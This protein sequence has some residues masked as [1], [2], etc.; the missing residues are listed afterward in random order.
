MDRSKNQPKR[1]I[2]K[3]KGHAPPGDFIAL[4]SKPRSGSDPL[5]ERHGPVPSQKK[6]LPSTSGGLE[7]K[8]EA[9][10][11]PLGASLV[12]KPKLLGTSQVFTPL[13]RP[14]DP[15]RRASPAPQQ[16]QQY[17]EIAVDFEPAELI[18]SIYGAED[19]GDDD[20]LEGL[21]CGAVRYLRANRAKP[22]TTMYLSL[23][24]LA[25]TK[26]ALFDSDIIIEAMCS[27]LKRDVAINFKSKGNALV[28]VLTCNILMVAFQDEE[29]WPDQF[30]KVYLE[31]SLGERVW[32]DREDCKGFVENI[33][34]AFNTKMPPKSSLVGDLPKAMEVASAS[35]GH[36]TSDD[37]RSQDGAE[38]MM[39]QG[40]SISDELNVPVFPRYTYQQT[41]IE[42]FVIDT[43]K[44]QLTRRQGIDTASRNLLKLIAATCGYPEIRSLAVQRLEMWLQN[45][46]LTRPAQDLL[47][48]ICLNCNQHSQVDVDIMAALI[49]IR[50]KTKPL[51]NQYMAS[52]RELLSQ[53]SDNTRTLLTHIVY[54]ELSTARNPNNMSLIAVILQHSPESSAR[55][56]AEIFQDFLCNKDDYLRALRALLREIVRSVK[57]DM[58][59]SA[60]A[61][62]LMQERIEA[63]LTDLD[64]AV[65]DRVLLSS[66]DL[67]TLTGLMSVT[68][69][70]REAVNSFDRGDFKDIEVLKTFQNQMAVIQRDSVWWLHTFVPKVFELKPNDYAHCL[71]KLLFLEKA[72]HYYNKD[73]WPPE[74]DRT[75][76]LRIASE[77]PVH[78]DTLMRLLIIGLSRELPISNVDAIELADRLIKR[79]AALQDEGFPVLQ[80]ERLELIDALLNLSTYHHPENITLPKGYQPPMLAITNLYWK[81]WNM[82][83]ILAAF[84]PVSFGYAAWET[85]PTLK[86]MMEMVMTNNYK[87][88]PPTTATDENLIEEITNREKQIQQTEKQ[89]I[90]EFEGHLAAASRPVVTITESNSLLIT[91]LMKMEPNGPARRPPT[92]VLDQL[93]TVNKSL[94]IGHMLC[95]SR[96]P[97]FLMDVIQ[98]QGTSSSMPWL[99]ELVESSDGS[100][101]V[102]PVQ[103]LCEFL[104][105]ESPDL[106]SAQEEDDESNAQKYK[107]KQ[108]VKKQEQLLSRLQKLLYD[109]DANY[110]T[111]VEVIDYF[112]KRLGNQQSSSRA[113]AVKGLSMVLSRSHLDSGEGMVCDNVGLMIPTHQ[114]LLTQLPVIPHFDMVRSKVCNALRQACQMETDVSAVSAYIVFLSEHGSS[115]QLHEVADIALDL[116]QL[117]VERSSVM[118]QVMPQDD[119]QNSPRADLV[120]ASLINFFIKYLRWAKEPEK[121]AYSWSDSQ[122][123][124]LLKWTTGE[125]A[126]L[127]ILVVHA[128]IILLTY[129]SPK[130]TSEFQELS[131]NWFPPDGPSPAAYLV[132]TSE[133]ALLLPDWLKLRMIRSKVQTLVDAALVDLEPAQLLLFV[134]SFGI[135][136]ESMKKLLQCLDKAVTTDMY[137]LEQHI[138]DK[139]YMAQLV[140]VQHL[141]GAKGGDNFYKMLTDGEE[142]PKTDDTRGRSPEPRK[143]KSPISLMYTQDDWSNKYRR[144]GHI[145]A[146]LK[147]MFQD[148]SLSTTDRE[149]MYKSLQKA[150]MKNTKLSVAAIECLEQIFSSRDADNFIKAMFRFSD[151]SCPLLRILLAKQRKSTGRVDTIMAWILDRATDSKSPLT[152]LAKQHFTTGKPSKALKTIPGKLMNGDQLNQ[153]KFIAAVDNMDI[154]CHSKLEELVNLSMKEGLRKDV[155]KAQLCST[156]LVDKDRGRKM[157]ASAAGLFIDWL[158]LLDPEIIEACPS[159]VQTLVFAKQETKDAK[160][161]TSH[162]PYL[163]A[164]LTHQSSWSS[165]HS[166]VRSLLK[167]DADKG[168][169]ESSAV[170]DFL[171]ACIHIPKIWQGRERS[172]PKHHKLEDVFNLTTDQLCCIVDHVITEAWEMSDG[173]CSESALECLEWRVQLLEKCC[174]NYRSRIVTVIQHICNQVKKQSPKSSLCQHLVLEVYFHYP[175][176]YHWVSDLNFILKDIQTAQDCGASKLDGISHRLLTSLS[177]AKHGSR[178]ENRM[179]D[180]NI[181]CRKMATEHPILLLR[182]LPMM[183]ALLKGRTHFTIGEFRHKNH[184]ILFT[185]VLGILELLMPQVFQKEYTSLG[186]IIEAYFAAIGNYG[187]QNPLLMPLINKFI[188][189]IHQF[190]AHDPVRA[191]KILHNHVELLNALTNLLPDFSIL[192]S[193]LAGLS[194]PRQE[195]E[196][197]ENPLEAGPVLLPTR[198]S[199]PWTMAELN[200]FLVKIGKDR[201]E[202]DITE[203]LEDLDNTAKR[204]VEILEH[205][206]GDLKR[207]IYHNNERIRNIAFMLVMRHVRSNPSSCG[208]FVP[209]YIKCLESE[210]HEVI[211]SALR[212]L[213]EFSLLGQEHASTILQKAFSAG[214][215]S[216]I[217]MGS[218]ITDAIQLLNMETM[219]Q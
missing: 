208:Q 155:R 77:V 214:I 157:S 32:V 144:P 118:A 178:S 166:C 187:F 112:L 131:D 73:N 31:D 1:P 89:E 205:F 101:D 198:S 206:L 174:C 87:F 161:Q 57:Y 149:Q 44:D 156:F 76:L 42:T 98:R 27:L 176:S 64:S 210:N 94:R 115:E 132:D 59:F 201:S 26:Q 195:A 175:Y 8:R 121:E 188:H 83:L 171:W 169:Y 212:H 3:G 148:E 199:S 81:A 80:V 180:A 63:K 86:Y 190:T 134:Q 119:V 182:Q 4:G 202:E 39:R 137:S 91:Q 25:K 133:E 11:P 189:F 19:A 55:L 70:V 97:D 181:A 84:N 164:L 179:Y 163:L 200:P 146:A 110:Q 147:R 191:T 167:T 56:L 21:I 109:G 12:K 104:L 123:Q 108:K 162:Q 92:Q 5:T 141:R 170:L 143:E 215:S 82:L 111:S 160:N 140:E 78:E 28:S 22:E 213:P 85:Y 13:G 165:L 126:T 60:F 49:K 20:K 113:L 18:E 117:I 29:N 185:H 209:S 186:D 45:P 10:T 151:L 120:L 127:H 99:A 194:L 35:P 90:L 54:N 172:L 58:N 193:L 16:L 150:V 196:G 116:S 177:E 53:H 46:K 88:P 122:D 203:V 95:R 15:E 129:G 36:Y 106:F 79:A 183:A 74:G 61:L 102:L 43:I 41:N 135:P 100:L 219:L 136:V 23:M 103:C 17:E 33:Q 14:A 40:G 66:A 184:H 130:A 37:D 65:K 30:L 67:I 152:L 158:E 211:D 38:S 24:Y 72:E 125:S 51:I 96:S 197:P 159:I 34:S 154:K 75:M 128:M 2:V 168:W 93:K 139:Q 207:L 52:I 48:S 69:A 217:D 204:K 62:G 9:P 145:T 50:L 114:W 71:H 138:V 153:E 192:K 218:H 124:I 142:K 216:K 47:L 6:S 68:P 105:H 173:K 7:R 107:K